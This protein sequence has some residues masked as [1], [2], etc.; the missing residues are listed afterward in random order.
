M[1][2]TASI[3]LYIKTN[4][5][6]TVRVPSLLSPDPLPH[7]LSSHKPSPPTLQL[8]L[9][10]SRITPPRTQ[11]LIS[12]TQHTSLRRGTAAV[13]EDM[14]SYVDFPSP[15]SS[16][17]YVYG[18]NEQYSSES[19]SPNNS[20]VSSSGPQIPNAAVDLTEDVCPV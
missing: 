12:Y 8:V 19:Q 20:A 16:M 3:E 10:P 17:Y 5:H 13:M 15:P 11:S 7:S 14:G 1:A 9:G 18:D 6:G 2:G 4:A